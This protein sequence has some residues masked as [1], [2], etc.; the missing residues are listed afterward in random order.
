MTPTIRGVSCPV[1]LVAVLISLTVGANGCK[2]SGGAVNVHGHISYRGQPLAA[3]AVTFFPTTGRPVTAPAPKGEYSVELVPGDYVATVNVGIERPPG[4]KE[5]DPDP[6]PAVVLA[7]EYTARPK[8]TLKATVKPGQS[9]PID[10]DL[11]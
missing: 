9:E 7:D 1:L 10:F 4:F 2:K 5:G 11:K 8:S 6:K 3:S